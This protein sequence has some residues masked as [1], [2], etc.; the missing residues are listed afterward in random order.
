MQCIINQI[1]YPECVHFCTLEGGFCI[2]HSVKSGSLKDCRCEIRP[3]LGCED[4]RNRKEVA[5]DRRIERNL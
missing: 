2:D 3:D 5:G 4:Y 1:D